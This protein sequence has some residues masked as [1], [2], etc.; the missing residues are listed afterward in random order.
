MIQE[1]PKIWEIHWKAPLWGP[2]Q[3][4]PLT[5]PGPCAQVGQGSVLME[6]MVQWEATGQE[7]HRSLEADYFYKDDKTEQD[8]VVQSLHP[9]QK[10]LEGMTQAYPP[11]PN[12]ENWTRRGEHRQDSVLAFRAAST[13][14]L[15]VSHPGTAGSWGRD[16]RQTQSIMV[17]VGACVGAQL[18]SQGILRP[19]SWVTLG[20]LWG[21]PQSHTLSR[22]PGNG[23]C[24]LSFSRVTSHCH[25]ASL[26]Y[27]LIPFLGPPSCQVMGCTGL[28]WP[29][30]E[31]ATL[32]QYGGSCLP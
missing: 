17:T 8:Q 6:C 26:W 32:R 28:S 24:C 31:L 29:G 19:F 30:L 15:L 10:H 2:A 11:H 4:Q 23:Q 22:R 13:C 12:P 18:W 25:Q 5:W 7:E 9:V 1:Q 21:I 27:Q 16:I 20:L 14:I 3:D